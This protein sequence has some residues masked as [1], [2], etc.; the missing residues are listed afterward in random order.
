MATVSAQSF[1]GGKIP[2]PPADTTIHTPETAQQS[3]ETPSTGG[4]NDFLK[5]VG[6]GALQ[7]LQGADVLSGMH[8]LAGD[9]TDWTGMTWEQRAALTE[10][11]NPTQQA[12]KYAEVGAELLTPFAAGKVASIGLDAVPVVK[13]AV[14]ATGGLLKTAGEKTTGISVAMDEGTKRAVQAYQAEQPTLVERVKGLVGGPETTGGGVKPTTEANTAVRLLA[15]GTEWKLGVD[16][17]RVATKLW[18]DSIA[19]SLKAAPQKVDMHAFFNDLEKRV[20]S[21]T[22]DLTRRNTLLEALDSFKTDYNKVGR[23]GLEKLQ[24]YKEGWAKFVPERAYNG[25]PIAG[26]LNDVRNLA[27][28]NARAI[29][30]DQL[31]PEIKQAYIDYGNLKSIQEAGIKSLDP[32]RSKGFT[33]QAWELILDKAVTPVATIAGKTLYKIGEGLEFLGDG[34]AKTVRDIVQHQ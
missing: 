28:Q 26:A 8:K 11:D 5:G 4:A 15:P 29:I 3:P 2:P 21:E 16:A 9:K 30:Y 27:A 32:L 31:G 10:P 6:K 25:K 22:P 14:S 20:I 34:G 19:P 17:K 7:T 23:I 1:F 12:G 13:D 24:A 33:K 18:S